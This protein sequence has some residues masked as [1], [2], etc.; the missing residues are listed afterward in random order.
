[1]YDKRLTYREATWVNAGIV[2]EN[3]RMVPLIGLLRSEMLPFVQ[4]SPF[5]GRYD[6]GNVVFHAGFM[7]SSVAAELA[8][9]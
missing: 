8:A 9:I 5:G 2:A 1:M 6:V 4:H 7:L 3:A